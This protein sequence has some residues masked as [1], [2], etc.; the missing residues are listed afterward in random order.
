MLR[1]LAHYK[2]INE[3]ALRLIRF[4]NLSIYEIVTSKLK[5]EYVFNII[6]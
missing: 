3:D 4:E 5:T 1:E 6:D 2:P